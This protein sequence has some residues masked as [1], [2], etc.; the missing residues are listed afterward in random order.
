MYQPIEVV[1]PQLVKEIYFWYF[2]KNISAKETIKYNEFLTASF[3]SDS[4]TKI[5]LRNIKLLGEG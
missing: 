4:P 2:K 3:P 5:F 1:F